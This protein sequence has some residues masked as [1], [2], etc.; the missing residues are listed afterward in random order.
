MCTVGQPG[1]AGNG[2]LRTKPCELIAG[3][4]I[5][6]MNVCAGSNQLP[7]LICRENAKKTLG[8]NNNEFPGKTPF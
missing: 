8:G 1:Q 5:V 2:Y 4:T 3:S 6:G 7:C